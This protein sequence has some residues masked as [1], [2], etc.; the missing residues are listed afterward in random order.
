MTRKTNNTP[1]VETRLP[2]WGRTEDLEWVDTTPVID[3]YDFG[4][5]YNH[6]AEALVNRGYARGRTLFGAPYDFRRG[7]S[8]YF[9][10]NDHYEIS[11]TTILP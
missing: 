8:E 5:Y 7:P 10:H 4:A 3:H 2:Q 9:Y 1:G 6:I 11:E